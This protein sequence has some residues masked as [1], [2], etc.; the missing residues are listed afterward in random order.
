MRS[1]S[2]SVRWCVRLFGTTLFQ[3]CGGHTMRGARA[4]AAARVVV[5]GVVGGVDD[6]HG[7]NLERGAARRWLVARLLGRAEPWIQD[8]S[9]Q[10]R[11]GVAKTPGN[12][13]R[14]SHCRAF[15]IGWSSGHC[16]T[17][18]R[19]IGG[20][21][22][23]LALHP[24]RCLEPPSLRAWSY[25]CGQS[26]SLR[27]CCPSSLGVRLPGRFQTYGHHRN[28]LKAAMEAKG[29]SIADLVARK[30]LSRTGVFTRPHD[31]RARY[32]AEQAPDLIKDP[33]AALPAPTSAAPAPRPRPRRNRCCDA[34][35]KVWTISSGPL[36]IA[37]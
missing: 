23:V 5:H 18:Q 21:I 37:V 3:D 10:A 24:S 30:T 33:A 35:S 20:R 36:D 8:S 22:A 14:S 29:L 32:F 4:F 34:E 27:R 15:G 19:P 16:P 25:P 7:G 2:S 9:S 17:A 11:L 6:V 1:A 26:R 28:R 31:G 12:R 13:A